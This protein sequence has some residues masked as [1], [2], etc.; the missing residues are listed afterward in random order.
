MAGLQG[1]QVHLW[2]NSQKKNHCFS[3]SV[4]IK[5]LATFAKLF[6]KRISQISA[7]SCQKFCWHR[8]CKFCFPIRYVK[9]MLMF[10]FKICHWV[11]SF[12]WKSLFF[13]KY[14]HGGSKR[15]TKW[16]DH[17]NNL[18]QACCLPLQPGIFPSCS[19][20]LSTLSSFTASYSQAAFV[21][22]VLSL[23]YE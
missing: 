5:F 23:I 10:L 14:Q 17:H 7:H 22:I 16:L 4:L 18:V 3:K 11:F 8:A 15:C 1:I 2:A 19:V 13:V 6:C 21:P 20:M 12:A 9:K